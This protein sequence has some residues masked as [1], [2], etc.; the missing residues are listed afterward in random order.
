MLKANHNSHAIRTKNDDYPMARHFKEKH[1]SSQ[2]IPRVTGTD[3][4]PETI[5]RGDRIKQLDQCKGLWIWKL[6]A[7]DYPGLN[8]D[9]AQAHFL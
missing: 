3:H 4:I 2:S 9:L 1:N 7:T 8:E 5:H 6:G